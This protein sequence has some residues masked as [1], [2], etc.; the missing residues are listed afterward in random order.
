[1]PPGPI[2]N[3]GAASLRAAVNPADSDFLYFVARGDGTH[4]FSRTYAE[5]LRAKNGQ[6]SGILVGGRTAREGGE[7]TSEPP[8]GP[9]ESR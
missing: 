4:T 8:P 2:A 5:H 9:G 1:L 7:I 3:A 6:G